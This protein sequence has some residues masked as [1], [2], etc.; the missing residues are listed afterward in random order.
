M[1]AVRQG[2][3]LWLMPEGGAGMS[4]AMAAPAL[5]V[6]DGTCSQ[7]NREGE[8]TYKMATTCVNCGTK[9]LVVL[10]RGHETPS[11]F[12]GGP[13]CPG[14]GNRHWVGWTLV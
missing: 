3:Y 5:A 14:C 10:S 12:G 4:Q 1:P 7:C 8:G 9:A 6:L 2:L 11:S 13:D